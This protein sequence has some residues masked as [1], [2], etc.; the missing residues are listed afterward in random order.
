MQIASPPRCGAAGCAL[1][2]AMAFITFALSACQTGATRPK[3]A[4]APL[5]PPVVVSQGPITQD[6]VVGSDPCAAR[7]HDIEGMMLYYYAVNKKMPEKL[8]ELKPFAD[9]DQTPDFRCPESGLPYLYYPNGLSTIGKD[10]LIV[11]CDPEPTHGGNRYCIFVSPHTA[12]SALSAE[13]LPLPE[14]LFRGYLP[15]Q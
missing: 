11:I 10:K 5:P 8:D 3:G 9:I 15:A 2:V 7:L 14:G 1:R 12:G 4:D 6:T 13:V